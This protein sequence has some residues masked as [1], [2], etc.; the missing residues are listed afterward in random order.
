MVN[1]FHPRLARLKS[2]VSLQLGATGQHVFRSCCTRIVKV[3]VYAQDGRV[4]SATITIPIAPRGIRRL[5]LRVARAV[6]RGPIGAA[7]YV[8]NAL[9]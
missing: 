4:A 6:E 7:L 5:P 3:I 2:S 1:L 8:E 9:R